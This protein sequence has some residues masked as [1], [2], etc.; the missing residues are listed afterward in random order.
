MNDT[1]RLFFA[2]WPDE[3][4]RENITSLAQYFQKKYQGRAFDKNSFHITLAF[5]GA[6]PNTQIHTLEGIG[7]EIII[8][9]F[10]LTICKA[11]YWKN[12]IFWLGFN[13]TPKELKALV[14]NLRSLLANNGIPFDEKPFVPHVTLLRDAK[15]HE[16]PEAI[17]PITFSLKQ[18]VLAKSKPHTKASKYT[19]IAEFP[20]RKHE[21]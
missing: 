5:L 9:S 12:K 6:I 2:L 17:S 3:S 11:S 4:T 8:P 1:S 19:A 21:E 15:C 10:E 18:F 7:N 16:A 14:V 20:L 13:E